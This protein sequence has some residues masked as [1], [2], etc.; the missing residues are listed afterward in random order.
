MLKN[1]ENKY[2]YTKSDIENILPSQYFSTIEIESK[3]VIIKFLLYE[4][5]LM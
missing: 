3:F 2:Q 5:V 4:K 1:M